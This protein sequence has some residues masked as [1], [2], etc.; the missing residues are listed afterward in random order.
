MCWGNRSPISRAAR[1]KPFLR[2]REKLVATLPPGKSTEQEKLVFED[3]QP[4]LPPYFLSKRE[5]QVNH[6]TGAES[7]FQA[8]GFLKANS[9]VLSRY[10]QLKL[11]FLPRIRNVRAQELKSGPLVPQFECPVELQ[12]PLS[13]FRLI[14]PRSWTTRTWGRR[15]IFLKCHKKGAQ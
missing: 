4:E 10:K 3:I 11:T 5:A 8:K 9:P 1:K 7:G 13:S 14:Q 6:R 15:T 12:L 2:A